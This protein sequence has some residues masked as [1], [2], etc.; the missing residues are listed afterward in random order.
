MFYNCSNASIINSI[1]K[2]GSL[3]VTFVMALLMVV[4][5]LKYKNGYFDKDR[6]YY[7]ILIVLFIIIV[8]L[9]SSILIDKKVM[10]PF[11]EQCEKDD[12][13]NNNPE[14]VK[15]DDNIDQIKE[16]L[17]ALKISLSQTDYDKIQNE[18]N[19]INNSN[20]KIELQ[21]ELDSLKS[22]IKIN[23][24]IENLKNNY[25][26][27]EYYDTYKEI[28]KIVD[29]DMKDKLL[30][31]ITSL[32][33]G[34]PLDLASGLIEQSSGRI[35]YYVGIPNHPITDMPLII[36]MQA[37]N[38][39]IEFARNSSK[40]TDEEFFFLAPN[41]GPYN[42]DMLKSFKSIIDSVVTRYGISRSKII[43][44]G[45]SNGALSTLKLVSFFPG[46]FSKAVPISSTIQQFSA[47]A[48][49]S[50][51]FWG[52]CGNKEACAV[53]MQNYANSITNI[54]GNAI[55][56]TVNGGHMDTACAFLDNNVLRWVFK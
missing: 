48:Y 56:T 13:N 36:V 24:T 34:K 53:T 3:I 42:D 38:C 8:I 43:I 29:N 9:L 40:F 39:H 10:S 19:N 26:L 45:H 16:D 52:I 46:Y 37:Y 18:I 14:P 2:Y 44:T 54:G 6:L 41:V 33:K 30:T 31:N 35:S 23:T 15:K 28:E 49:R 4:I 5:Y 51:A 27:A 20:I 25:N 32:G 50:T 11:I 47:S 7:R 17:L 21:N 12:G 55:A 22:F 1:I